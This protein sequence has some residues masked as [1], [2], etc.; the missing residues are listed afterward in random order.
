MIRSILLL[1]RF[2]HF[3][4]DGFTW[5]L[6]ISHQVGNIIREPNAAVQG[7]AEH[8]DGVNGAHGPQSLE[9][10]IVVDGANLVSNAIDQR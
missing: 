2:L 8:A 1:F 6:A 4:A 3:L 9:R 7:L 5:S 10:F